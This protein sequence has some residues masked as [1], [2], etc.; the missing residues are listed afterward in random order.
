MYR[1]LPTSKFF[2]PGGTVSYLDKGCVHELKCPRCRAV[3]HLRHTLR[4]TDELYA[5]NNAGDP[6][7]VKEAGF[8]ERASDYM[9]KK[10]DDPH[11]AELKADVVGKSYRHHAVKNRLAGTAAALAGNL[12]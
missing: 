3:G 1:L 5:R 10:L 9:Y 7:R 11:A 12:Y 6:I 8:V 2:K 4:I